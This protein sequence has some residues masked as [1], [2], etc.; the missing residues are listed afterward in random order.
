MVG[1]IFEGK[2]DAGVM[3]DADLRISDVLLVNDGVGKNANAFVPSVEKGPV[4]VQFLLGDHRCRKI[5]TRAIVPV[6][7]QL[8]SIISCVRC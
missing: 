3:E 4:Y 1:S 7:C 6:Q 5:H 2:Y 8:F